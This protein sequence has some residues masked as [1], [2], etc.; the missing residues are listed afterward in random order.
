M[1][2]TELFN[3]LLQICAYMVFLPRANPNGVYDDTE[4][5]YLYYGM[6]LPPWQ[7]KFTESTQCLE[8]HAYTYQMLVDYMQVQESVHNATHPWQ[9]HGGQGCSTFNQNGHCPNTSQYNGPPSHHPRYYYNHHQRYNQVYNNGYQRNYNGYQA[10]NSQHYYN[11][12]YNNNNHGGHSCSRNNNNQGWG[13][14][15]GHFN[16]TYSN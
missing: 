15:Q 14:H 10:N 5:K 16:P 3:C 7:L 13:M 1:K 11:N 12:G 6:M 4:T 2:C 9:P 8:D